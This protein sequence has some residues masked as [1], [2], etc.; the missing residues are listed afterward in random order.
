[1]SLRRSLPH[2][3]SIVRFVTVVACGVPCLALAACSSYHY[4]SANDPYALPAA[5]QAPVRHTESLNA[6][7]GAMD[8]KTV[9]AEVSVTTDSG[10]GSSGGGGGGD[11]DMTMS[12]D[13]YAAGPPPPPSPTTTAGATGNTAGLPAG[14]ATDGKAMVPAEMFD[15]EAR[16]TLEVDKIN[17]AREVVRKMVKEYGGNVIGDELNADGSASEANF[18]LRIPSPRI[19]QFLDGINGVGRVKARDVKARDVG[20]EYHDSL[21]LLSNLE[22]TMA[23]Y[24][25]ILQKAK[26]VKE[27]LAIETELA[28]LRTQIDQVKGNITWLKDRTARSTVYLRLIPVRPDY[29]LDVPEPKFFP[30]LRASY[31]LDARGEGEKDKFV[32]FGLSLQFARAFT[33]DID[34]MRKVG[35]GGAFE[36][37][38][39]FLVTM[40]GDIYSDYFGAGRRRWLNPYLGARAGYARIL[41]LNDFAAT[42]VAGLEIFKSK[43]FLVDVQFRL[44]GFFG[45]KQGAH[46]GLQPSAGFNFAF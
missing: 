4:K 40:G 35:D 34:G 14:A 7:P 5:K 11:G 29:D 31:L 6:A 32:G 27:I 8:K 43:T 2:V 13:E 19:D 42:G 20:K 33:I 39:A 12:T 44:H 22:T 37:L 45:N 18:E 1:M 3:S 30:G 17:E 21:L 46:V 38:Q 25:D 26:D 9:A 24:N 41:G 15:I 10:E 28:R 36:G 23:R 16:L